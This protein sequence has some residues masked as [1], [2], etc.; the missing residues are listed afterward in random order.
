MIEGSVPDELQMNTH[1]HT[2]RVNTLYI[3]VVYKYVH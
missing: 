2:H 1:T 3:A